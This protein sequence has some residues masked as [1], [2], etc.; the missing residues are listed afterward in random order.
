MHQESASGVNTVP[1]KFGG[2]SGRAPPFGLDADGARSLQQRA[3]ELA[4]AY[5][6]RLVSSHVRTVQLFQ[7][8][9]C[10][11]TLRPPLLLPTVSSVG[12]YIRKRSFSLSF[13]GFVT[14]FLV[15]PA[16]PVLDLYSSKPSS[17]ANRESRQYTSQ[18]VIIM[19]GVNNQGGC[20]VSK[21]LYLDMHCISRPPSRS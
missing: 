4:L 13:H 3:Q 15:V 19:C 20:T 5:H 10:T 16:R 11:L 7:H 8:Q 17:P 9:H 12:K 6:F 2:E 18:Q 14:L 21:S 1:H